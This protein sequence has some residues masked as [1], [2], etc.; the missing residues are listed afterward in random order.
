MTTTMTRIGL[1]G[2]GA[3]GSRIAGR[4][5]QGYEVYGT[6]RSASKASELLARG[7]TWRGTPRAV[8]ASAEVIFSMVTDDAALEAITSGPDG[9]LA[10]LG[11]GQVFVDM[12]T[13]TPQASR[14]LARSA[15]AL[16]ASMLDAPVSATVTP[17][18]EGILPTM[19]GAP[20]RPVD[21]SEP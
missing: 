7:M 6:N 17:A 16:G 3:M 10:G 21:P 18:Q 11:P 13:V 2:V 12:S 14:A 4:L 20:H 15:R 8:A 5:L 9:I 1:V 19:V